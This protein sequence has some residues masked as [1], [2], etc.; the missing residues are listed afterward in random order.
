MLIRVLQRARATVHL[1]PARSA[2]LP[3]VVRKLSLAFGEP[4]RGDTW[5]WILG[6][7]PA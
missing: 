4:L 7:T 1:R 3:E 6:S 5:D 2:D